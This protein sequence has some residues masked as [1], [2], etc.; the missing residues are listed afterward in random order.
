MLSDIPLKN[1]WDKS[2]ILFTIEYIVRA[3]DEMINFHNQLIGKQ[4]LIGQVF[5]RCGV[6]N[7]MGYLG[8]YLKNYP[9]T[10]SNLPIGFLLFL[11]RIHLWVYVGCLW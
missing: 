11:K 3:R 1:K 4:Q 6:D 7:I 9:I 2:N 10:L 5:Y 8:K